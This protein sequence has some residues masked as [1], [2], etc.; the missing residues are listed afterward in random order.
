MSN[1]NAS[2]ILNKL[3]E[4]QTITRVDYFKNIFKVIHRDNGKKFI[5][6]LIVFFLLRVEKLEQTYSFATR[7]KRQKSSC[8]QNHELF[9]YIWSKGKSFD[10]Y[11]DSKYELITS[12]VNSYKRQ[13]IEYS[14][15]YKNSYVF[16]QRNFGKIKY[17]INI[18]KRSSFKT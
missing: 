6:F 11:E 10:S 1:T 16:W 15:Q 5:T 7:P 13:S 8:E 4:I 9:R 12:H 3:N 14:T 18:S 17:K 2:T